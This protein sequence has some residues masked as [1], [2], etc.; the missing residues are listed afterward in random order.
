M[1]ASPERKTVTTVEETWR[2]PTPCTYTALDQV[3]HQVQRW[4]KD[5]EHRFAEYDDVCMVTTEDD[6]I[7]FTVRVSRE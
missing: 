7:V 3:V 4:L 2:L 6:D 5:T 1:A